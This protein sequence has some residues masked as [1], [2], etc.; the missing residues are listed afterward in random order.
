MLPVTMVTMKVFYKQDECKMTTP[1]PQ[2]SRLMEFDNQQQQKHLT[3]F[4]GSFHLCE[5]LRDF[6]SLLQ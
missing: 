3:N 2:T 6:L 4:T 1:S 5:L